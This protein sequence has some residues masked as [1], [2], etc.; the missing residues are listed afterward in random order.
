VYAHRLRHTCA[1]QLLNSGCPITSIQ[2]LLGHRRLNTTLGYARAHD[3]TVADDYYIAMGR[4]E[5][6]LDLAP[7]AEESVRPI[8]TGERQQL[9]ALT[10]RLSEPDLTTPERLE[11]AGLMRALLAGEVLLSQPP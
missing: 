9:L 1:T 10:D 5:Q 4:V 6:R 8:P 11:L 3:Q 7:G 2:K